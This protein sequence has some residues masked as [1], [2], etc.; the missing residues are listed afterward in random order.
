[1][2]GTPLT[3]S[4]EDL[5]Q[6]RAWVR[7]LASRLA[8]DGHEADEI[9]QET[10][11]ASL[12]SP[13]LQVGRAES[14]LGQ[15]LRNALR[16]RRRGEGRRR[17]RERATARSEELAS[18]DDVVAR[19]EVHREV[20][21]AVLRLDEPARTLVLL[22][23]FDGLSARAIAELRAEPVE[24]VRTRLKRAMQRL[25]ASL[26]H[27]EPPKPRPA[28]LP[29]AAW[30]L[31]KV[32]AG[33]V[34]AAVAVVS[35]AL[36]LFVLQI[37]DAPPTPKGD[38]AFPLADEEEGDGAEADER[39]A[40]GP[41]AAE[42]EGVPVAPRRKAR[43]KLHV[44][45]VGLDAALPW[46]GE[47]SLEMPGGE[48]AREKGAVSRRGASGHV[49]LEIPKAFWG[50]NA[51]ASVTLR[52]ADERY[53]AD[54]LR[55]TRQDVLASRDAAIELKVRPA[56]VFRGRVQDGSGAAVPKARVCVFAARED[57]N[58][59][60]TPLVV[61]RAGEDGSYS[62]KCD[63]RGP[64]FVIAARF[65]KARKH[66]SETALMPHSIEAI[67]SLGIVRLRPHVLS[68][69]HSLAGRVT[70]PDGS[71][72]EGA[73][74]SVAVKDS[75]VYLSMPD[76]T[77]SWWKNGDVADWESVTTTN[78]AGEFRIGALPKRAIELQL[79]WIQLC[80]ASYSQVHVVEAPNDR[81]HIVLNAATLD[82]R[83][84]AGRA[85]G[86]ELWLAHGRFA[87][88]SPI[89]ESGSVRLVLEPGK[90]YDIDVKAKHHKPQR[91][92]VEPERAQALPPRV[93]TL[94]RRPAN[95]IVIELRGYA[96]EYACFGWRRKSDGKMVIMRD[97]KRTRGGGD[98]PAEFLF[99]DLLP[100]DYT[101]TV[102]R[103]R[104]P[105]RT[106]STNLVQLR[107]P[108]TVPLAGTTRIA[109]DAQEGGRL[110]IRARDKRGAVYGGTCEVRSARG[111]AVEVTFFSGG[112]SGY[113][114]GRPGKLVD[115]GVNESM[116]ALRPGKYH[117]RCK[118]D[119]RVGTIERS[120]VIRKGEITRIEV[121]VAER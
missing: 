112:E 99:E 31:F 46:T 28:L 3:P 97:C 113:I 45:L 49:V 52:G 110:Q 38:L 9:V 72:V 14:W 27:L 83:V 120:F 15:V 35:A 100:G 62:V 106:T 89:P 57:G 10:W 90:S 103:P 43:P 41:T 121:P 104:R 64:V 12:R 69:G 42:R 18:T 85:I 34:G 17:A 60:K 79:M 107:T 70:W 75:G 50:E 32:K 73:T 78:E 24:T 82:V 55:V 56:A 51:P 71:P 63:Y 115:A 68:P 22:R 6:H 23:Y 111:V 108:V 5:L 67:A 101:L 39:V 91:F 76:V 37:Q 105:G 84:R 48:T 98:A 47:V 93:V 117:L 58:P 20:V 16:Q 87:Q 59:T 33:F 21:D 26:A 11:L 92:R 94:E 88:S 102:G 77:W 114:F 29:L 44:S 4:V 36:V 13:P 7:R 54:T 74:L 1:M 30:T 53:F 25:R 109:L 66:R 81:V 61:D 65:E 118:I 116:N 19:A 2:A 95:D 40:T 80:V 8:S 86:A 96:A 119:E